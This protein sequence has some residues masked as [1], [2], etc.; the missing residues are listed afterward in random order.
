MLSTCLTTA[1]TLANSPTFTKP[2]ARGPPARAALLGDVYVCVCVCV[3]VCACG[4]RARACA[5]VHAC[6]RA[7]GDRRTEP[8]PSTSIP[9]AMPA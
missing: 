8:R 9:R 3:C 6:V 1:E 5:C 4:V 7:R 2:G